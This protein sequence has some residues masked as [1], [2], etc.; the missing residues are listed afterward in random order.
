MYNFLK[1][2]SMIKKSIAQGVVAGVLYALVTWLGNEFF[3]DKD[4]SLLVVLLQGL[5]FAVAMSA[6]YYLAGRDKAK[7]K[8]Q[9]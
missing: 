6:F 3:F 1:D 4:E 7:K 9:S 2:E 8:K 5:F